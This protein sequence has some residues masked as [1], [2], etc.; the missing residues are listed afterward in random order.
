MFCSAKAWRSSPYIECTPSAM[1]IVF[2]SR[3]NDSKA[4]HCT[5]VLVLIPIAGGRAG[6]IE[7]GSPVTPRTLPGDERDGG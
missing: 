1:T 5:Q 2:R 7:A 4:A 6:S 3:F